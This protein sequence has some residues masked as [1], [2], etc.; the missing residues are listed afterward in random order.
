[1]LERLNADLHN[2][3]ERVFILSTDARER[4]VRRKTLKAHVQISASA[5]S[6]QMAKPATAKLVEEHNLLG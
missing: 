1:M 2:L 4:E 5:N 6:R 3:T